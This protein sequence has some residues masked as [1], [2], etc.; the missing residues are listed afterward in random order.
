MLYLEDSTKSIKRA[1]LQNGAIQTQ[2]Y[3]TWSGPE[4]PSH[5]MVFSDRIS[6]DNDPN[7]SVGT[8]TIVIILDEV[9]IV[10][11]SPRTLADGPNV[12]R[13]NVVFDDSLVGTVVGQ[14]EY[15]AATAQVAG[16]VDSRGRKAVAMI[17]CDEVCQSYEHTHVR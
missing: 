15:I 3:A 2:T 16:T 10:V 7:A 11:L 4:M 1:Y 12:S 14:Y 13:N 6:V 9:E 5:F 17:T 8:L